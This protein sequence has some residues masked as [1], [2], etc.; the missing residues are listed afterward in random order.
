MPPP[1]PPPQR[2]AFPTR[3][4]GQA[5][6]GPGTRRA[7]HEGRPASNWW[8]CLAGG[9]LGRDRGACAPLASGPGPTAPPSRSRK[10]TRRVDRKKNSESGPD[11]ELGKDRC[12][13]PH[14]TPP[15][16]GAWTQ[17]APPA[18]GP[19]RRRVRPLPAR[20]GPASRADA[21]G[22]RG[23]GHCVTRAH[24]HNE[25]R[26]RGGASAE[27]GRAGGLLPSRAPQ[28]ASDFTPVNKACC[29][30]TPSGLMRGVGWGGW[31]GGPGPPG[32][33]AA[34]RVAGGGATPVRPV[35]PPGRAA[36]PG[37]RSQ[38]AS[39]DMCPARAR[40]Q[41]PRPSAARARGPGPGS[42]NLNH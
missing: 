42:P 4:A 5:R 16:V 34:V 38:L 2:S 15:T 9:L 31:G 12:T 20:P 26:R 14:R 33:Y 37:R 7:G 32:T 22:R 30:S 29:L 8:G 36:P 6:L 13:P 1:A 27:Q 24:D 35:R 25:A 19:G 40:G 17:P 11:K 18:A 23:G 41:V 10:V 39:G 21:N 3:R 28:P